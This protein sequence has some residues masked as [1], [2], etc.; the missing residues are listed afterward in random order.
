M[1]DDLKNYLTRKYPEMLAMLEQLVN[2]DSGS[3]CKDG[4]DLCGQLVAEQLEQLEFETRIIKERDRGNHVIARRRGEGKK[5]LFLSAHLDTVSPAGTAAK[6]PFSIKGNHL[7]GPGVGD[8]KGGLVQ[9][10]YA[11]KALHSLDLKT[12]PIAVFLTGDEELGSVRGRPYIEKL[13]RTSSWVLVLESSVPPTTVVLKRWGVGA[14]ELQINGKAA[15]VLDPKRVGVNACS[16][17]AHKILSLEGISDSD[18]GIRVSVNQASGGSARQVTASQALAGIDVRVRDLDMV[19]IVDQMVRRVAESASIQGVSLV[20]KGGM[21]RPP[22]QPNAKTES[23]LHLV[24]AVAQDIDMQL[25]AGEKAGGSDGSFTSALGT[26]TLDG[27]GLL[28]YDMCSENERIE[29]SS[30]VA[31]TLLLAGTIHRL[32]VYGDPIIP[33]SSSGAQS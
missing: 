23:L 8:M 32:T 3:Y 31:R 1:F 10:V 30:I 2:I 9:L 29:A 14:F 28:G 4:I 18:R 12:P 7:Y 16:E 11:L 15:H 20:L 5:Q 13:A 27:M 24:C 6:H 33:S 17:L 25:V 19:Q 22:M 21:T 26:A